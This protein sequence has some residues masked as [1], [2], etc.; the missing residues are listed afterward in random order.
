MIRDSLR[1]I[2]KGGGGGG[3]KSTLEDILDGG[4]VC[5]VSNIQF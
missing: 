3:G 1:K 4:D 2:P 5:I